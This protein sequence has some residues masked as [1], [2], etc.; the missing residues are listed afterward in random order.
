VT[1]RALRARAEDR[2]RRHVE[3]PRCGAGPGEA[4]RSLSRSMRDRG[5]PVTVPHRARTRVQL[6]AE[7]RLL[8]STVDQQCATVAS[9][10]QP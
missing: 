7:R 2:A 8:V 5:L 4:C 3:C 9:M 10:V 1:G 6:A